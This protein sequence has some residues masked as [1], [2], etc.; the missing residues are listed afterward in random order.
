[1]ITPND[2]KVRFI[3]YPN[4]SISVTTDAFAPH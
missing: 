3:T 1:M 2:P 4:Q